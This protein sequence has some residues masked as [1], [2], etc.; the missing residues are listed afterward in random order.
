VNNLWCV[1]FLSFLLSYVCGFVLFTLLPRLD[2]GVVVIIV[3]CCYFDIGYHFS[4]LQTS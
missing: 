3:V 4:L 1:C 2:L